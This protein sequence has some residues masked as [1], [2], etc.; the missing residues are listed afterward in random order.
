MEM[1][2][3]IRNEAACYSDLWLS[4]TKLLASIDES[5]YEAD[6]AFEC[7][8]MH[9]EIQHLIDE[10]QNQKCTSH[11]VSAVVKLRGEFAFIHIIILSALSRTLLM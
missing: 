8:E 7:W 3:I 9:P 10:I 2:S 4:K 6:S 5:R 1:Y 11:V